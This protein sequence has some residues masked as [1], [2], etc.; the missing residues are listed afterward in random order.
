[1]YKKKFSLII[2]ARLDSKRYK[3]KI[4]K[5]INK[6]EILTIMLKR[7]KKK[8]GSKKIVVAINYLE[9]AIS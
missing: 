9:F 3:G 8:F 1:M 4:L 2:Q 5:K 7:L 6:M